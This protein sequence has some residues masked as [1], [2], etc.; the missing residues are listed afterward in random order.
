[1]NVFFGAAIQG[2]SDR[3]ERANV[4]S[5]II[6]T[7]KSR[8]LNVSTEHTT[9]KSFEETAQLLEQR[10]GPLPPVGIERSRYVRNMMISAVEGDVQAAIFEVSTPSL[11]T[12]VEIA[13]AYLRPRMGLPKIP[14]LT[15]YEKGYWPN[16]AS[17]MIRGITEEQVDKFEFGEYETKDELGRLVVSFLQRHSVISSQEES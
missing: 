7:I 3:A 16:N 2:A 15:L 14:I 12:G 10:F 9:G 11:G 4:Y 13:H 17:S 5:F 6:N 8:D 1:M